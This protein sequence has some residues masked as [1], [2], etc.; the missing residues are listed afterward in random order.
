MRRLS[1]VPL[2]CA[3]L[4]EN[5]G[6]ETNPLWGMAQPPQSLTDL[7][8]CSASSVESLPLKSGS[9]RVILTEGS[10][11]VGNPW[12]MLVSPISI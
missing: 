3:P 8:L 5:Q 2:P 4:R 6:H 9:V 11:F 12:T 10:D 7:L 1:Q